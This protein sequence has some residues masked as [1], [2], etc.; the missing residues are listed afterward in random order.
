M[1]LKSLALA[2]AP[3]MAWS[4]RA[5]ATA[6]RTLVSAMAT[7]TVLDWWVTPWASSS[8]VR[9]KA[10]LTATPTWV[11][12]TAPTLWATKLAWQPRVRWW[13]FSMVVLSRACV[14]PRAP[15][16]VCFFVALCAPWNANNVRDVGDCDGRADCGEC[17]GACDGDEAEGEREGLLDGF[18]VGDCDGEGDVQIEDRG[19]L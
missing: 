9:L 11:M 5:S 3:R 19:G 1:A 16:S 13:G 18:A 17:D 15:E 12:T 14:S 8:R 6:A 7:T 10:T 2:K 4:W